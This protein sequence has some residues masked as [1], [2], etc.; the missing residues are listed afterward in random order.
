MCYPVGSYPRDSGPGGQ[1]LSCV[2]SSGELG[3]CPRDSGPGGQK[4]SCV[5]SGGELS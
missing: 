4:L 2:L 1:Y 5:L 3:S